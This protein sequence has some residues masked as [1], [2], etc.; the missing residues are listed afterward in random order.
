MMI[1]IYRPAFSRLLVET[2]ERVVVLR[3]ANYT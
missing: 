2:F 3:L 1:I